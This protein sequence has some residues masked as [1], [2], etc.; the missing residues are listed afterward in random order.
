MLDSGFDP[1]GLIAGTPAGK[2]SSSYWLRVE[3][4]LERNYYELQGVH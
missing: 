4:R 3:G 2:T 1:G